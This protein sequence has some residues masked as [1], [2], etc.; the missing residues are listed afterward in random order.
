MGVNTMYRLQIKF[1]NEWRTG[2]ISYALEEAKER[3]A[4]LAKLK[5]KSR[6]ILEETLWR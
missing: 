4:E 2:H 5:I 3:Q 6:I 1:Y